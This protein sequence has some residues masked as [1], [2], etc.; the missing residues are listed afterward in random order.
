MKPRLRPIH[1]QAIVITGASSGI[2]L[3]TARMAARQGADVFLIARDG[4]ALADIVAELE[5]E[6][7]S[8]GYAVADVGDEEELN[9]AAAAAIEKF[10]G[11]DTWV[12]NAGVGI[13]SPVDEVSTA[14]HER[15]FRTNYFG[16]VHGSLAA[17]RHFRETGESGAIINLGSVVS[18]MPMILSVPYAATKH[19]VK[20]FTDGL[21]I[22]VMHER[23]P[24]S[25]TLVKPSTIDTQFFEH[26]HTNTAAMGRG[27]G[28]IYTPDV[29]AEA[30]LYAASHVKRD[31]TIGSMATFGGEIAALV[32]EFI[33]GFQSALSYGNVLRTGRLPSGDNLYDAPD[34]GRETASL[35]EARGFSLTTTAQ[36][37]PRATWSAIAL[38]AAATVGA[39]LLARH[40]ARTEWRPTRHALDGLT[41][42]FQKTLRTKLRP[43]LRAGAERVSDWTSRRPF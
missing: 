23:L 20:G 1:D 43:A 18:D 39:A 9:A 10:G 21:R 35:P 26:A 34:E 28:K 17:L 37:H 25:V 27:I 29:V 7:L 2:G 16:V 15:L 6:G 32:P 31:I 8:A 19:A 36:M 40:V 42:R 33:D 30:I 24:I 12:N 4:A 5:E 41:G 22:E 3:A 14:D 38:G 11:F 13:V